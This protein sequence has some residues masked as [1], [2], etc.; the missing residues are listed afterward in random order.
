ME[1]RKVT[2]REDPSTHESNRLERDPILVRRNRL[3]GEEHQEE[4]EDLSNILDEY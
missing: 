2:W 3:D 4:E 1:G